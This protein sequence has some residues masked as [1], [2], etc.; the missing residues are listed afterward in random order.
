[1]WKAAACEAAE[2]EREFFRREK[3]LTALRVCCVAGSALCQ[4][5][6]RAVYWR[7]FLLRRANHRA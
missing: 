3:Y 5:E 4:E 6:R 7:M 2:P 1:V